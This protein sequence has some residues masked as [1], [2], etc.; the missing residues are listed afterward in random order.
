MKIKTVIW[1]YYP[2][3]N[4][5]EASVGET[6]NK[7]KVIEI[8]WHDQNDYSSVDIFYEDDSILTIFNPDTVE[9]FGN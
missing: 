1:H 4:Y 2:G 8:S 5:D 7:K 3:A 6:Y 9:T